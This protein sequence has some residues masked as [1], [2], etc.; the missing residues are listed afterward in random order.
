MAP[1]HEAAKRLD[2]V[3]LRRELE[4]GVDPDMP[5]STNFMDRICPLYLV[6]GTNSRDSTPQT[7][8]LRLACIKI[9]LEAGASVEGIPP[10][11]SPL[12][13]AAGNSEKHFECVF[14]MLLAAGA[15]INKVRSSLSALC[16]AAES[17]TAA[18]VAKIISAG[19][20]DFD[21]ALDLAITNGKIR[22]C[23]PLM[24]AGAAIPAVITAPPPHWQ[25]MVPD[26]P[27]TRAYIEKIRAAGG[28]KAYEKAHR[29]RLAAILS[30]FPAI[31]VEIL[32]RIVEFSWDIGGH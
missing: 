5:E 30:R 11:R 16:I 18:T 20:M 2:A 6:V 14:D 13:V 32:E 4:R 24:R 29:Q 9:L 12:H 21:R 3:A 28:Y 17:G 22:N 19:A 15:D 31:P 25:H 27:Q 8:G 10:R 26:F 23:A 7:I 1:I